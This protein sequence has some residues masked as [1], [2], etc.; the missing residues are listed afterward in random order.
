MFTLQA[1]FVAVELK[2]NRRQL[3]FDL[4]WHYNLPNYPVDI[5]P[6]ISVLLS[7]NLCNKTTNLFTVVYSTENWEKVKI[8][9]FCQ[10]YTHLK[11]LLV[12]HNTIT[13][14]E[15]YLHFSIELLLG[16]IKQGSKHINLFDYP[17]SFH[18]SASSISVTSDPWLTRRSPLRM[19]T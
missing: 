13:E 10:Q 4:P 17:S 2:L 7:H 11:C 5:L 19:V 18:A 16:L 8:F 15:C 6:A 9:L 12:N 14:F 1:C 3:K